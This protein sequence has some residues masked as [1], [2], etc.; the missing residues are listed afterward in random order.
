MIKN[1]QFRIIVTDIYDKVGFHLSIKREYPFLYKKKNG[2][3]TTG[4]L[5]V[6]IGLT[7]AQ[8]TL[9]FINKSGAK[10]RIEKV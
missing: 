6:S 1:E 2:L 10:A 4:D 5:M 3:I 9:N 7:E 8:K